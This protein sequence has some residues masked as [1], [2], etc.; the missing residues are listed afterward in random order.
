ME[1]SRLRRMV[2]AR[3]WIVVAMALLGTVAAVVFTNYQNE[4]IAERHSATA[5]IEFIVED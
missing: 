2:R 3:W 5:V 1:L 4:G